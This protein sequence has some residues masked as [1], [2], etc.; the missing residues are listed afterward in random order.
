MRVCV[1]G[2]KIYFLNVMIWTD[3][4]RAVKKKAAEVRKYENCTWVGP[5]QI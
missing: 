3:Y 2:T 4:K 1:Y 5:L